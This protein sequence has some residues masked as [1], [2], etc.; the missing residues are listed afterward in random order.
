MKENAWVTD[1]LGD[2]IVSIPKTRRYFVIGSVALMSY[3]STIGYERKI[4][5]IDIICDDID[6]QEVASKLRNLGYQQDTF[7]DKSFPLFSKLSKL[8]KS[9]YFRFVK[10]EKS[11]EIMTSNFGDSKNEF[12]IE[13]YPGINFS[14]PSKGVV[15]SIYNNLSFQAVSKET[16]FCIYT[17]GMRT[18]GRFVKTNMGQRKRDVGELYKVVDKEKL[19]FIASRIYLRLGK[20]EFRVPTF[21]VG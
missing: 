20:F 15:T 7:V 18:W 5:D 4:K 21:I 14:F 16:L 8:S 10:E 1:L 6:F 12:N 11:L 17:F 3:T 19:K 9:K 2:F 13:V